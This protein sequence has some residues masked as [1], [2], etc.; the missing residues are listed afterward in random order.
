MRFTTVFKIYLPY[1]APEVVT[2]LPSRRAADAA[3]LDL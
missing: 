2:V 1:L 3:A